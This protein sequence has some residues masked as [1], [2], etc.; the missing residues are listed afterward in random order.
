VKKIFLILIRLLVA[1]NLLYAAINKFRDIPLTVQLFNTMSDAVHGLVSQP[2]FRIGVG[3][4]E[5]LCA[6]LFLVPSTA[7]LSAAII[8]LYM[9]GVLLSHIF[10]LGYGWFF[11]DARAIFA[12][13]CLYLFLT[14]QRKNHVPY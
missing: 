13:S 5:T 10:V 4:F 3:A 9:V 11:V 14:R 6:I 8:T 7:R 1:I 2:V 12:L